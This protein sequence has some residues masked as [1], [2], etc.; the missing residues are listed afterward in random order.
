MSSKHLPPHRQASRAFS[1]FNAFSAYLD[2]L[3]LFRM[4]PGL[5][6]MDEMLRRLGLKSPPFV[7]V[8]IVGTNGKGSTSAMLESLIR[9]HG[10]KTGLHSSPHLVSVRER[11]RV[12]GRMLE[13]ADWTSLANKLMASGG[14][15]LSYFEFVTCLAVL[16]FA[17]AGVDAAI[18]ETGLGGL[19]DATSALDADL[20]VFTPFALDHQAVLGETL[21]EIAADKA[22]SIRNGKPALSAPQQPEALEEIV[23]SATMR[24]AP[25]E[26]LSPSAPL[27]QAILDGSLPMRLQADYQLGNARLALAAWR[28][29]LRKN[30]FSPLQRDKIDHS[31]A[32]GE[33]PE[34]R[35]LAEA[36]LPGRLQSAPPLPAQ[37]SS[38]SFP[39][40]LGWPHMLLDG[41]HNPHGMA[42]L[43]LALAKRGI[44]PSAVIFACVADKDVKLMLPHLRSLATGP[45][46][47]P[48]IKDNPRSMPP[49]KLAALIGLNASP[50]ASLEDALRQ[51]CAMLAER[52][53]DVFAEAPCKS[54]LLV[55]G[56]LYLLGEFFALRG[57]CLEPARQ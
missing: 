25:L 45:I 12:N 14:K 22:G 5:E 57:D 46:F 53:P 50:A 42:A 28:L 29:M 17:E 7:L 43:G 30:L 20:L 8:Q 11:I 1:D 21:R 47:V 41:A 36:W 40:S 31:K 37:S 18:M 33:D 51:A 15:E 55:C 48:P 32:S 35:A 9:A 56:S 49:E 44:A 16:A 23:K 39:C 24:Q 10:L 4:K 26:I 52:F 38:A 6:R 3:G 34:A 27:P 2:E 13:E 19:F 54:P